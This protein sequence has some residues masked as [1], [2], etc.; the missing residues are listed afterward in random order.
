M[1]FFGSAHSTGS[2]RDL[3]E[4][5]GGNAREP[6]IV[7][8]PGHVPAN[9][10]ND[11]LVANYDWLATFADISGVPC[12]ANTDGTSPI[13]TLTGHP[14]QQ[15]HHPYLYSEYFGPMTG[16]RAKEVVARHGYTKRGSAVRIGDF[17]GVRYDIQSP[18]DP[19]RLYNV[20][21]DPHEDHDLAAA[22]QYQDVLLRMREL[23]ITACTPALGAPRLYDRASSGGPG[24]ASAAQQLELQRV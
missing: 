14:D 21:T 1:A 3:F 6:T 8:W 17:V 20:A 22:S 15:R 7:R 2:K 4:A 18:V 11:E 9:T 24:Q 10:V 13:P 23:L 5:V 16:P 19:L 12:P